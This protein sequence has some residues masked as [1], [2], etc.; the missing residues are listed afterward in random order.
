MEISREHERPGVVMAADD[1]DKINLFSRHLARK[2]DLRRRIERRNQLL[3]LHDD[4]SDELVFID[5]DAPVHYNIG[6]VFILEDKNTVEENLQHTKKQIR[7][8]IQHYRDELRQLQNQMSAL[9][10]TLYA[11]FGKVCA[12]FLPT[13]FFSTRFL[14]NLLPS[15]PIFDRPLTSKNRKLDF[16]FASP[17]KPFF[18]FLF[19][20][21]CITYHHNCNPVPYLITFYVSSSLFS[22]AS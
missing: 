10:A 2:N 7:D 9:K 20:S 13:F 22:I 17:R 3:Q 15:P 14:S 6:D 8:D 18:L 19:Y 12:L 21:S 16:M 4:A 11:K 1:R 5:D